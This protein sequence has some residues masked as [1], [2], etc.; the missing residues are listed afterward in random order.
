MP[1]FVIQTK[2]TIP[3]GPVTGVARPHLI[4]QLEQGLRYGHRLLSIIAPAGYGKTTLLSEWANQAGRARFCWFSLDE[5]DNDPSQFWSYLAAALGQQI[6]HLVETIQTL[7]QGGPLHSLPDDLILGVLINTLAQET[8]PL[9]LVLD[10]YHVIQNGRI[11]TALIQ[12]LAH[13]PRHFH[14]ALTSRNEPPLDLARLRARSQLTEIKMDTLSFSENEAT[15]FLNTAMRLRLSPDE[16]SRLEQRTEGWIAGLQLAAV[17]LQF[18]QHAAAPD[19]NDTASF[20]QAFGGGHR[21]VADY[22]TDEVLQR[23]PEDVQ[24]FLLQTSILERLTASL[25][26]EVTDKRD[27]QSM[28]ETLERANLF[29]VPL[30]AERQWYRYH[31]LWAE[32]LRTRLKREHPETVPNLHRRASAWFELHDVLAEAFSHALEAGDSERAASL[33]EPSAKSIVMRGESST[34]LSWLEKLSPAIINRHPGLAIAQAWALITT[35][36][37]DEL[38]ALLDKLSRLDELASAQPGE[39]AA[40]R[41]VL[42]TI[43]QDIPAIQIQ[44]KLALQSIP[45]EDSQLRCAV[46]LSL[47]TAATLSGET[48]QAVELLSQAIQESQRGRQPIIHLI[49]I[50]T[51]AQAYESLGQLDQAARFHQQVIALESDPVL[52][53][54]PLIGVGYV[55]L[56][57]ILH[58]RL[59]FE[60]A[61]T[62]LEKGLAIGQRWGSPEIL[63]GGYFS[64]ARL[65]Y[66][67]GNL[68]GALE[69]LDKLE[70]EFI[71]ISPLHERDHIMAVKA[72][73]WLAQG[74]LAKV[75][76]WA[77]TCD[78]DESKLVNYA[79]E[80]QH[81][82]LMRVLLARHEAGQALKWLTLFEQNARAA[83]RTN[84]LI[85]ILLLQAL[86]YQTQKQTKPALSALEQALILSEPASQR[87]VFVDEP[88]LLPLLQTCLANTPHNHFVAGLL[89][90]FERRAAALQKTTALLSEREMDVLHLMA[91][92]LSNQ[93]I[94]DRLVVALS[95]I[96]SH[97]KNILM[98]L[99]AENRTQAVARAKELKLI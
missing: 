6:P 4:A 85:E 29:L 30:D 1:N 52:G 36:H 19:R 39:I 24:S 68:S 63:I 84:N 80:N 17:A 62:T 90:D 23:Q 7:L 67:Q 95:T 75:T 37:M 40:I 79:D 54:L 74:Q 56:G 15:V 73:I 5:Q 98:K 32:M 9:V 41:S 35:G 47:G 57:G 66:T 96:K 58:E 53:S 3:P 13:L 76:V 81:L 22:L 45:A 14:L 70:R 59:Q 51:L 48:L 72:R 27:S 91:D 49:A 82:V 33:I 89:N 10:D 46:L 43:R 20:I 21:H 42:A 60:Q 2:I 16:I 11:H 93:D 94:A 31:P 25:C 83:R 92:G 97:V 77:Q 18:I 12:L 71:D 28:L 38:E 34:L 88:E 55:G 78:L 44:A 26:N 64:L 61:E 87:R 50:S 69:I 99:E 8:S 65:R 86:A